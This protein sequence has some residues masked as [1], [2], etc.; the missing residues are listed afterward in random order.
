VI[1][2]RVQRA[3]DLYAALL[4]DKERTIDNTLLIHSRFRPHER[5]QIQKTLFEQ[6]EKGTDLVVVA[7]Q[8]VE[9]GVD[10]SANRLVTELAPWPSIVQRLGRC[11]RKGEF[12]TGSVHWIDLDEDKDVI[13]LPYYDGTDETAGMLA[14]SR[15]FLTN[16]NNASPDALGEIAYQS[17]F[18][19]RSILR[20]KDLVQ[21]FDS[22]QD[23]LGNDIDIAHFIRD[24]RDTDAKIFWRDWSLGEREEL[25]AITHPHRDELCSVPIGE[26]KAFIEKLRKADS[27][28][29]RWD[30][31]ESRWVPVL[32]S[33]DCRPG[34]ILLAHSSFGGYDEA[35]GWTGTLA[36][37]K[38][39]G[40]SV[41][42]GNTS[43]APFSNDSMGADP[44]A[45]DPSPTPRWVPLQ[46]HLRDVE[47][48][49]RGLSLSLGLPDEFISCLAT[50]GAW[51][52]VGK[53]HPAFQQKLRQ[54]CPEHPP[55]ADDECYAKSPAMRPVPL[56]KQVRPY[57]RHELAS[58]LSWLAASASDQDSFTRDLI[59]Y[60]V[61]SHHG[62]I[63]LA[64][65]ALPQEKQ[66]VEN[67]ELLL[68]ARGVYD[69]ETLSPVTL[70]D[71][72]VIAPQP[73]DLSIMQ[74]GR[75][76]W[77]ERTLALRD[78]QKLGPFRLA[79]LELVLRAADWRASREAFKMSE[80][81]PDVSLPNTEETKSEQMSL[82][83]FSTSDTS[84]K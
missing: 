74:M 22:T 67:G 6:V 58:A 24:Q 64:I 27:F 15:E 78:H 77:V 71:G 52:D 17:P 65:K 47:E 59:A 43:S 56:Y 83:S 57:F 16:L 20:K 84:G 45:L 61:M 35:L 37:G 81:P 4:K 39:N 50:A 12:S 26:C 11:N 69:G 23:L 21:L 82:L 51:H 14:A 42:P 76:S 75:G 9:A 30:A 3:K 53:G 44:G 18:V 34:L 38:Q 32:N 54:S 68:S 48:A 28:L 70:P 62:K 36:K 25:Q 55:P 31:L 19:Q 10:I 7:T 79:F 73:L 8:A 46:E 80:P 13:A 66:R 40:V 63:R 29:W 72:T 2:N 60:L 5:S 49:V 41:V 1:V 33:K